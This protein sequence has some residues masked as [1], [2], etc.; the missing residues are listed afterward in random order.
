MSLS[1]EGLR[2]L[3][4]ADPVVDELASDL[5]PAGLGVGAQ[6]VKLPVDVLLRG[7]D[8]AIDRDS[9]RHDVETSGRA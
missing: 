1:S 4:A 8:A 2:S 7:R 6:G 9:L 3:R 5:E